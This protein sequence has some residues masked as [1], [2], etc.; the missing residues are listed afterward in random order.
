VQQSAKI[1]QPVL[2]K[3]VTS[4]VPLK[5]DTRSLERELAGLMH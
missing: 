3:K 5:V 4:K 2:P 1:W